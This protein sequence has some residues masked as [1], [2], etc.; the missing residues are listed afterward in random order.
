MCI[1]TAP[2]CASM[3][4][5]SG[6]TTMIGGSLGP[7]TVGIDCG[8]AFNLGKM[9][10]AAEALADQ[11][12]LPRARQ[13]AS[14]PPLS[15]SSSRPACIG[16]KIHED[17]GVDAGGRSTPACAVADELDFQVQTPH[18]HAERSPASSKIRWRRSAAAPS[19]CT[20]PRA[21]AAGTRRTSSAWPARATACRPRPTRPIPT[22]ST[23]STS[24]ST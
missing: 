10:Q 2:D 11:F 9:L 5:A 7:I 1:S 8:G 3:R 20:T 23:P 14:R 19:T 16:L 12:R 22:P 13:L 6:I 21:P 15:S 24:T 18:R 4:S 17:W